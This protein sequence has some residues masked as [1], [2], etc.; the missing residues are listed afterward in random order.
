[1]PLLIHHPHQRR[2]ERD[3]RVAG[4]LDL[5][6]TMLAQVLD[7]LPQG[8]DGRR[9]D[10]PADP[11]HTA[12]TWSLFRRYLDEGGQD[13]AAAY[14]DGFKYLRVEGEHHLYDLRRDPRGLKDVAG[15]HPERLARLRQQVLA[16]FGP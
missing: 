6:P 5:A 8:F 9:L 13:A 7:E 1:M 10:L 4:H 16:R 14:Q 12:Y 2:A 15:E 11:A 3:A